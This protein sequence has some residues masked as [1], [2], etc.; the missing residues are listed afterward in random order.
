MSLE[1]AAEAT[2]DGVGNV[3]TSP[4]VVNLAVFGIAAYIGYKLLKNITA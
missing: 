2:L 4:L 1:H 3:L